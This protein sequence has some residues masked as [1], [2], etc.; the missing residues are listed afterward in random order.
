[1]SRLMWSKQLHRDSVCH[2]G[3]LVTWTSRQQGQTSKGKASSKLSK[4]TAE[5]SS[6][7]HHLGF[8]SGTKTEFALPLGVS[9]VSGRR[10]SVPPARDVPALS[11]LAVPGRR[12]VPAGE[13]CGDGGCLTVDVTGCLSQVSP[14]P[15]DTSP[16]RCS[17]RTLM[18]KPWIC[19]LAVSQTRGG[20]PGAGWAGRDEAGCPSSMSQVVVPV[21]S[22]GSQDGGFTQEVAHCRGASLFPNPS[23]KDH[24]PCYVPKAPSKARYCLFSLWCCWS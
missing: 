14:V 8:G 3:V 19:G 1:M 12:A 20:M 17:G 2:R 11:A 18:A 5:H 24:P 23:L 22:Q 16:P 4:C 15:R 13:L 9:E 7:R 21:T 10:V 6:L